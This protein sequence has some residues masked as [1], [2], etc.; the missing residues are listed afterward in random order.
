MRIGFIGLGKMGAQMVTKLVAAGHEVVAT[1]ISPEAVAASVAGGAIG[2]ADQTALV[3]ALPQ[4]ATIWVMIPQQ[5]VDATL[6]SLLPLLPEGS[7][8]VDGGNSDYRQ[9]M[10]RSQLVLAAGHQLVDCGTSGGI[11]GLEHGFSMMLGGSQAAVEGLS[12]ILDTLSGPSGG[13]HHFGPTGTGHYV[14]MVHNGIE[15]GLMQAYA[16]GYDLLSRGPL[17]PIDLAAV[18]AVWQT[19]SIVQSA[20]GQLIAGI[21]KAD[22][23]LAGIEGVVDQSGEGQW[24]LDTAQAAGVPVPALEAAL[25]TRV[26]SQKGQISQA[27]RLLAAMRNA[28]GGHNIH[29]SKP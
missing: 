28:F 27:T 17:G 29:R 14:K 10:E 12:P 22:P 2:A 20:L 4:P 18:A 15:Y 3:Q 24:T 25:E 1:D 16:E 21:Y 13:W 6:T 5:F 7:T 23:D 19:G 26:S 8:I 9:T 11:M